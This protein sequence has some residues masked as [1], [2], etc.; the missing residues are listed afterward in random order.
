MSRS[1]LVESDPAQAVKGARVVR[2]RNDHDCMLCVLAMMGGRTYEETLAAALSANGGY[3]AGQ[4]AMTHALLRR[5][6]DSWGMALVSSIYMDWRYPGI[7]GVLSRTIENCGHALYWD[8]ERLIDPGGG[9][10]YDRAYVDAN[11]MEFTQRASDIAELV[12]LDR[13]YRAAAGAV[14]LEEYF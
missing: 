7:V 2:Q 4:M 10:G 1:V 9:E 12:T 5:I 8:G 14:V 11:A 13:H 6:A 3:D